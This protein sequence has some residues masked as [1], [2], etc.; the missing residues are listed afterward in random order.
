MVILGVFTLSFTDRQ[1]WTNLSSIRGICVLLI[2]QNDAFRIHLWCWKQ[3]QI[4]KGW[5]EQKWSPAAIAG[6]PSTLLDPVMLQVGRFGALSLRTQ[7]SSVWEGWFFACSLL[8][9]VCSLSCWA[10]HMPMSL[11]LWNEFVLWC[12]RLQSKLS[13][14]FFFFCLLPLKSISLTSLQ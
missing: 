4:Q 7:S 11:F 8:V 12:N 9:S 6:S 14:F 10:G 13:Y 5:S 2:V 1:L 3:R